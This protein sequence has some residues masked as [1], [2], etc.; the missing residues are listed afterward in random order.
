MAKSLSASSGSKAGLQ[1]IQRMREG[2]V[3]PSRSIAAG[4]PQGS[5]LYNEPK[6]TRKHYFLEILKILL[7]QLTLGAIPLQH[8]Q[9]TVSNS[10]ALGSRLLEF[11]YFLDLKLTTFMLAY[12]S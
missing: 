10:S 7:N 12:V 11:H 8:E 3:T 9:Q 1:L 6:E 5:H 2:H 4:T